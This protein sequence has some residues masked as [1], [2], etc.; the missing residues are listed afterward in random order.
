MSLRKRCSQTESATLRT[1]DP[2]PLHCATSPRCAHHWH[3]DFR[4]NSRRYRATTETADKHLARDIEATER[5]KIL[6]GRRHP[7][8]TGHHISAIRRDVSEGSRRPEQEERRSGRADHDAAQQGVRRAGAPRDHDASDRTVEAR[9]TGR[10][11]RAYGQR[12]AEAVEPGTVNREFDCL[13][14]ILSKA[15]EWKKLIDS[16]VRGV[17]RLKVENRRTRILTPDE[18]RRLLEA[19]PWK[20]RAL[21]LALVTGARVGELLGLRWDPPSTPS[22]VSGDEEREAATNPHRP[23][24]RRAEG[25]ATDLARL[26]ERMTRNAFT[27]NGAGTSS[28]APSSRW[29]HDG[30]RDPAHAPT[31]GL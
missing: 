4:V 23:A 9:S 21:V 15:V 30:R 2:N 11:W 13:R 5:T 20:M 28:I 6:D 14:A 27:V 7:P 10:T 22:D 29:H 25:T 24:A 19:A 26:H 12:S 8:A 1:G 16:P 18:Q 3:Y 17:K 31:Y